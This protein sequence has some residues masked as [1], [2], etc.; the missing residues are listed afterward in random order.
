MSHYELM[1]IFSSTLTE[2]EEKAQLQQV[3]EIA[4]HEKASILFVDHWGK[5]KLAYVIKKQRQGYYEWIYFEGNASGISEIDRKLKMS[6]TILR[7]MILKMEK[8][9]VQN[10][11]KDIERRAAR[12]AQS[13]AP[14]PESVAAAEPVAEQESPEE[15]VPEVAPETSAQ[16]IGG[17]HVSDE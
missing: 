14:A 16:E 13:E 5:R 4:K 3:E 7:F 17:S 8:I 12:L 2:D 9:Q 6:E 15:S 1:V 11:Q 10:L